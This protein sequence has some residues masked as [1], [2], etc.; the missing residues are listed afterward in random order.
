[1]DAKEL[2]KAQIANAKPLTNFCQ[3][4]MHGQD[5]FEG[6]ILRNRQSAKIY[7]ILKNQILDRQ[8][9]VSKLELLTASIITIYGA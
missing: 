4:I 1:M 3:R 8:Q 7:C 2:I 6:L 9:L 5:D